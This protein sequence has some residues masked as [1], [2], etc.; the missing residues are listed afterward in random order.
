MDRTLYNAGGCK[1]KT[2]HDA[3]CSASKPQTQVFRSDWTRR[4]N[5]ADMFVK[6]VKRLAKGFNFK[7]CDRIRFEDPETG[8]KYL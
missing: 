2:A 3:I 5:E 1:D 6:M 4:D 7:L 8:K